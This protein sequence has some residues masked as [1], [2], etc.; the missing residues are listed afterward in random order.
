MHA[1]YLNLISKLIFFCVEKYLFSVFRLAMC[2]SWYTCHILSSI[3]PR[4]HCLRHADV[5][6]T[7]VSCWETPGMWITFRFTFS[8]DGFTSLCSNRASRPCPFSVFKLCVYVC[9]GR[10]R[11]GVNEH[12]LN[13]AATAH[14]T[15]P[16]TR[17]NKFFYELGQWWSWYYVCV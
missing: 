16:T 1:E 5:M 8:R 6:I 13:T 17:S 7:A 2:H 9:G 14:N 10:E 12:G 3:V 15:V 4:V 11:G